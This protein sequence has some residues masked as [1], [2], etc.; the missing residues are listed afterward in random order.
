MADIVELVDLADRDQRIFDLRVQGKS[1]R[2]IARQFRIAMKEVDAIVESYCTPIDM[3]AKARA[4]ELEMHRIDA[5]QDAAYGQAIG[6]NISA[7]MACAKL[8]ERRAAM[9]GYEA[10]IRHDPIQ[11]LAQATPATTTDRIQKVLDDL[12]QRQLEKPSEPDIEQE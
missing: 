6:G 9:Y 8:M 7:I 1:V 10:P 5:L 2:T 4:F 3:T 11:V 12:A